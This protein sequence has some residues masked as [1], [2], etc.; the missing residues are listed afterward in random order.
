[1]SDDHAVAS[2]TKQKCDTNRK[3]DVHQEQEY[4]QDNSR[5]P[6]RTE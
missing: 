5:G 2:S 3:E 4:S 1:M 6:K